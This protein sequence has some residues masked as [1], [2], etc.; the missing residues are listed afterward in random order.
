MCGPTQQRF[1]ADGFGAADALVPEMA[2]GQMPSPPA[3]HREVQ[4][5]DAEAALEEKRPHVHH[6]RGARADQHGALQEFNQGWGHEAASLF[7]T[8]NLLIEC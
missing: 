3:H 5:R 8:F 4:G 6:Q 7:N 2:A 1:A